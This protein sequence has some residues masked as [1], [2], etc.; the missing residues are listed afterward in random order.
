MIAKSK[1]VLHHYYYLII[2]LFAEKGKKVE[3]ENRL[4]K[5]RSSKIL[6]KARI[7]SISSKHDITIK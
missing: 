7:L 6:C 3:L 4:L 1:Q 5:V 2:E